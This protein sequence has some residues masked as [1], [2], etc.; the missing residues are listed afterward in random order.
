MVNLQRKI[1]IIPIEGV[2]SNKDEFSL[3][4]EDAGMVESVVAQLKLAEE[5]S[6]IESSSVK[7]RLPRGNDNC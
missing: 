6:N 3:L 5:D 4:T 7:N 1:L 2:I